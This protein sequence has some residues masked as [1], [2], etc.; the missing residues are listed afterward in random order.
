[1]PA[2]TCSV[3]S[4]PRPA[5][6]TR[7]CPTR[8]TSPSSSPRAPSTRCPRRRSRPPSTTASIA[9]DTV[10]GAYADA[11]EV[12]DAARRGRRRLRRRHRRCS[13]TRASRSSSSPGTSCSTPSRPRCERRGRTMSFDIHL[14]GHVKAVVDADA[15][16]LVA[17]LVASRHHRAATPSLWGPDAEAEAS[18]R[19]GWIEAVGVSRPL[20]AE[21]VAL[22]DELVAKGVTH[23]VLARHGRLVARPRGHRADRR[24]AAHRPRLD[25]PRPG[26]RRARRRRRAGG[27]S[28]PCSSSRRSRARP[29]RP[30]AKR[31]F[32]AAFRD[33]GIDPVERIVVVTD[34][35]SPL[36][37]AARA[38]GYRVFN[39]DPTVGG[40]YSALT[41]FG[42]VPTGLAGVDIAELLDEA[43]A[44][45][46]E[47]AIDSRRQP[48]HSCSAAAIAGGAAAAA[49]SSASSPTAPTSSASPTGSSSS[50]PSPPARR[51]PASCPSSSMP[52]SPELESEPADLQIVRLVDEA[53][54]FHFREHH[55]GEILVS[56]SLG[57]AAHRVGVRHRDRRT[58]ARHQPVRPARRR[59][60]Q[61]RRARSAR[62]PP[63]ARPPRPSSRTASRCASRIP[64]SRRPEP[65]P[66]CSTRCW[67]QLPD[68]GYVAIQAYVDRARTSRSSQGCATSSPPTPVA[69][70]PSAG[71][72]ASCTR[73]ASSTRAAPPSACSCRS[74]SAPTSTSRSPDRPFTFGQLIAGPGRRRRRACS[75]STA[76]RC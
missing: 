60:G 21:I 9:G 29:S 58:D 71:A 73:P 55:E 37:E 75:P 62:R 35:G 49:T 66:A 48:R 51:A 57:G 61:D 18:Q 56:G 44:T 65:S 47:L 69:R 17:D 39:A 74:S 19:L 70:R 76:A 8:S 27:L 11:H 24:R 13:R 25:R 63:R 15:P 7:R 67:A 26:A 23:I 43:E 68:D 53:N 12:L 72:R 16:R 59:V 3:R 38:D 1:M 14:S 20:V 2:P 52:V 33:L 34:P 5:S 45:L 32:E 31:A 30:T 28:R 41:A 42:L 6:R 22:R 40:R 4:G 54:E 46:L 64:R 50:S 36:D 10:T